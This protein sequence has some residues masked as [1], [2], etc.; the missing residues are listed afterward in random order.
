MEADCGIRVGGDVVEEV[1]DVV[2]SVFCGRC[3]LGAKGSKGGMKGEVNG[4]CV[5][6]HSADDL[7]YL[8]ASR[9][10]EL[11]GRIGWGRTLGLSSVVRSRERMGSVLGAGGGD[12]FE[13]R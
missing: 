3:L 10:V 1:V 7:M 12:V 2:C 4:T 6:E 11:L 8:G 13:L 9:R 5:V